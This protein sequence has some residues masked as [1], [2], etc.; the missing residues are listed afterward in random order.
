MGRRQA[1]GRDGS[2]NRQR[3][4]RR[5]GGLNSCGKQCRDDDRGVWARRGVKVCSATGYGR[6]TQQSGYSASRRERR[7]A[8]RGRRDGRY[9]SVKVC[10][11]RQREPCRHDGIAARA[12]GGHRGSGHGGWGGGDGHDGSSSSRAGRR[13]ATA[14]CQVHRRATAIAVVAASLMASTFFA[15]CLLRVA[16]ALHELLL[17]RR[18]GS[19]PPL[20]RGLLWL[21][22]QSTSGYG[23]TSRL[24]SMEVRGRAT[25]ETYVWPPGPPS[26]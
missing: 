22:L 26:S 10:S 16:M 25:H 24:A 14:D 2:Q 13:E 15:E 12:L 21:W 9:R 7:E 6:G 8:A 1:S 5:L 23:L 3:H 17:A 19:R 4:T 11:S 20:P 18:R